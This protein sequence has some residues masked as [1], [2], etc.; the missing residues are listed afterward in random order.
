MSDV[1]NR[2]ELE[3]DLAKSIA[4]AL[5]LQ[6]DEIMQLLGNPPNMDNLSSEYWQEAERELAGAIKPQLQ[7]IFL[8]QA[9]QLMDQLPVGVV[10]WGLVN[11]RAIEW[12]NAYSFELV[13]GI[14]DVTRR[15]IQAGLQAFFEDGG[16]SIDDLTASLTNLFGP[17]RAEMIA[18]T[19]VT[20]A[21][22]QGELAL[23][24]IIEMENSNIHMIPVWQTANDD[25]VCEICG[26]RNGTHYGTVWFDY[27]PAHPRCLPGDT[28]VLPG[29]AISAG[30]K[31]WYEGNIVIIETLENKLSVSPNH[32]IL[33]RS[34]WVSAGNLK[35]GDEI[36]G[37]NKRD[38]ESF[39]V[40]INNKNII[41]TI[42]DIFGSLDVNGFRVPVSAPDFHNDGAGSDIA[43]IRSNSEVVNNIIPK[44]FQ[45]LSQLDFIPGNVISKVPLSHFGSHAQFREWDTSIFGHNMSGLD[46]VRTLLFGHFRPLDS[47][48]FGLCSGSYSGLH[49]S[50]S[51][52][53]A[54]DTSLF[55]KAVFGF[56]GNISLQKVIKIGYTKFSGHV[57]NLQTATGI[58]VANGIITHNCRCGVG[59]EIEVL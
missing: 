55:S 39:C 40:G 2:K 38:W 16:M 32:P 23:V 19:E 59:Y 10:D 35:E 57:Y 47:F 6:F 15:G 42:Q 29:G 3:R 36:F 27:P 26:P 58:Y 53:G 5:G 48:G 1:S 18:I 22:V 8:S 56:S 54:A 20:R 4:R 31:R 45:P 37:Y 7:N 49:Q 51:K 33:T 25:R 21:S 44:I 13:S 50:M 9:Q 46:L 43:V 30:S 17:V 41:S 12:V 11:T 14:T 28:L 24:N 34:G 52:S